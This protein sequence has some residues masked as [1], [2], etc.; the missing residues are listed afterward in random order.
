MC[1]LLGLFC[2]FVTFLW[3]IIRVGSEVL[4]DFIGCVR[5][6]A[7]ATVMSVCLCV[8]PHGTTRLPLDGFLWKLIS[9]YF[10]KIYINNCPTRCNT[11]QSIYYSARSLYVFRV[12]TAHKTVTTVFGIGHIICAVSAILLL[13][14]WHNRPF[15]LM[16]CLIFTS[17]ASVV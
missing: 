10:S 15:I 1:V 17:T 6:I 9:E 13:C 8:C 16:T 7:R 4:H 12:S 5:K 3:H 2:D 11:K 14:F